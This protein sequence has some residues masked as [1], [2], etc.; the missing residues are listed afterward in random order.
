MS[1]NEVDLEPH[2]R[3]NPKMI[4]IE[5][6]IIRTLILGSL[7]GLAILLGASATYAQQGSCL[8]TPSKSACAPCLRERGEAGPSGG[9]YHCNQNWRGPQKSK[10]TPDNASAP[11]AKKKAESN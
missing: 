6:I 7:A 10:A 3:K 11:K 9:V 8:E 4:E 5:K 2:D 1:W